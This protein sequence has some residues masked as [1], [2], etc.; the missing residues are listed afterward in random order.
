M[1]EST[2]L[3]RRDDERVR[4]PELGRDA[5]CGGEDI[6]SFVSAGEDDEISSDGKAWYDIVAAISSNESSAF[7]KVKERL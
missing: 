7:F 3:C 2:F 6:R 1:R 4:V 5:A